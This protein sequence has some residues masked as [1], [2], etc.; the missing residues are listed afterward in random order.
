MLDKNKLVVSKSNPLLDIKNELGL[1]MQRMLNIYLSAINPL[2]EETK[3][4]RFSLSDFVE[5]L[6][7][8]EVS[9]KKLHELGK[10]A[11]SECVVNL[12][13]LDDVNGKKKALTNRM[14]Y[15]NIWHRFTID[16]D[17]SG[18]WYV[19][20]EAHEDVLPYMF[21]LKDLGYLDFKVIYALRMRSNIGEKLYEQCARYKRLGKFSITPGEL[22]KRLGVADQP[23]YKSYN[24]F[25]TGLL[26]RCMKEINEKTDIQVEITEEERLHKRGAPVSKITFSVKKNPNIKR[27]EADERIEKMC[28]KGLPIDVEVEPVHAVYNEGDNKVVSEVPVKGNLQNE[29]QEKFGFSETDARTILQDQKALDISDERIIE[30]VEYVI[31]HHPKSPIGYVRS[32]LRKPDADLKIVTEEEKARPKPRINQFTAME[33]NVYDFDALEEELTGRYEPEMPQDDSYIDDKYREPQH[34]P[35]YTENTEEKD[36]LPPYY[37]VIG[38]SDVMDRLAAYMALGISG[39]RIKILTEDEYNRMK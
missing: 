3:Y 6:D 11:V 12:Y 10:S 32:L 25:K 23:S 5:L 27:S 31:A 15:V 2:K 9:S 19:E 29:L 20:L 8:T 22:K 17:D 28:E 36:V 13:A 18:E 7:I 21:D 1:Y 14:R 30:V 34:V 38:R 16:K 33:N 26:L 35:V 24:R 39:E 37:I 4:V